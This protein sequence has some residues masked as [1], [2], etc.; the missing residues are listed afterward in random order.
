MFYK[1]NVLHTNISMDKIM[2]L[3]KATF[4]VEL[5]SLLQAKKWLVTV[6][7]INNLNNERITFNQYIYLLF[8]LHFNEYD[9]ST[10]CC[11]HKQTHFSTISFCKD[12]NSD[13]LVLKIGIWRSCVL[14]KWAI[15]EN[16]DVLQYSTFLNKKTV[17]TY[18]IRSCNI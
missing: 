17:N 11:L 9:T 18:K 8:G 6:D 14:L 3:F 16:S 1:Y 5:A 7:I 4:L 12:E 15:Q 10:L 13:W 2:R